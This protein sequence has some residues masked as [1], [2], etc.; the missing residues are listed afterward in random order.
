[1]EPFGLPDAL[2]HVRL[3][4]LVGDP[5]VDASVATGDKPLGRPEV[6]QQPLDSDVALGKRSDSST[7]DPDRG[8]LAFVRVHLKVSEAG[9]F[10]DDTVEVSV[11]EFRL[12]GSVPGDFTVGG[13]RAVFLAQF[14]P[15]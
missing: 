4:P 10:I 15:T 12:I 1:M 3:G 9:A 7:Q 5:E 11:A 6:R 14:R 8:L 2:E 13:R